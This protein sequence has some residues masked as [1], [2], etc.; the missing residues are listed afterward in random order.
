MKIEELQMV[1]LDDDKKSAHLITKIEEVFEGYAKV[2][3]FV[4]FFKNKENQENQEKQNTKALEAVNSLINYIDPSNYLC[5]PFKD[6]YALD[7]V[8]LEETFNKLIDRLGKE[9]L[10]VAT[11]EPDVTIGFKSIVYLKDR[12]PD[13]EMEIYG[14]S[15]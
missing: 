8:D 11:L 2:L 15:G 14:F 3:D 5:E 13:A 10:F 6:V 12:F 9:T 4:S 7:E 1:D